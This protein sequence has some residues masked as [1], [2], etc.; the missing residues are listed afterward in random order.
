MAG[1][2]EGKV[3]LITGASSGIGRA[4]A[5][6]FVDQGAKVVIGDVAVG[7]GEETA[8]MI[9]QKGGDV[10]WVKTDVSQ[11]A[12]VEAM[13]D[14]AVEAYGRLDFAFNNAGVLR[15]GLIHEYTEENW[16]R[17]MGVNLKGIWLCMKY[18]IPVMLKQGGGAIVNTSSSGGLVG[19]TGDPA[20]SASKHGVIGL[21]KSAALQYA[22]E[23]IRINA[24]C[25]GPTL[26]PPMQ[27]LIERQPE[28]EAEMISHEPMGRWGDPAEIAATALWLCSDDASFVTG[29]AM[30]V[31]G[32]SV[33]K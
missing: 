17:V 12:E 16:D 27:R 14:K 22:K 18:E 28:M 23:G 21:T 20:Y 10:I 26:S 29:H 6:A 9:E 25:P 5:L 2:F 4:A 1:Q 13:V 19:L 31:D 7:R 24:V 33:I 11:A 8:G 32:G 30:S 3:A 15:G